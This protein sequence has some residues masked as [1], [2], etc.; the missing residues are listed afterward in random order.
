MNPPRV[1]SATR[2]AGWLADRRWYAGD[3]PPSSTTLTRT[4]VAPGLWL[5]L[6]A[7][8]DGERYQL[9]QTDV[10]PDR[11]DHPRAA[12]ALAGFVAGGGSA[13]GELGV[14]TGRWLGGP[15]PGRAGARALGGEQSNT[16]VAVGGTHLVKVLRRLRPGPHP[17]VEVGRHLA[18]S[19]APV[20]ALTGW[21]E[22]TAPDGT[23]TV[24]GTVHELV[25]GALDGWALT[26]SALAAAPG[27]HLARLRQLGVAIAD[28]HRALAA[29]GEGFGVQRADGRRAWA[30]ADRVLEH[31]RLP[32]TGHHVVARAVQAVGDDVGAQIRTHGDLH[33]GQTL[34]GAG[35]WQVIDFEGEPDRSLDE[36]RAPASPLR[37]VA[38]MLRSLSYAVA[39][40]RRAEGPAVPDGWLP[41]ARAALLDGYLATVDPDLLPASA[42]ATH[43][44]LRLFELEKVLYEVTYEEAYRPDWAA[45]PLA[46]LDEL[47][48]GPR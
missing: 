13:T 19:G 12:T 46:A 32:K 5:G 24:L 27:D 31:P 44:L 41:A 16:S 15:A 1:V 10:Q 28:L 21:W 45:I 29:P 14:V 38:G 2:L 3:G 40:H 7:T 18:G 4:E 9:V 47:T 20:P 17:E 30:L 33:L 22:L 35:G 36:R 23:T 11:A 34:H 39:A 26:L 42:V 6:V 37:D 43:E 8:D 25:V 48:G